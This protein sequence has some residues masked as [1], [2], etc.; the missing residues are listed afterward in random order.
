[1]S[2]RLVSGGSDEHVHI[3]AHHRVLHSLGLG[4]R[5]GAGQELGYCLALRFLHVHG[6]FENGGTCLLLKLR[7]TH[8]GVGRRD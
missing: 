3:L 5:P 2:E 1:M 7:L 6:L 8:A 4:D